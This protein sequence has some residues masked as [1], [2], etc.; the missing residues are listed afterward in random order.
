MMNKLKGHWEGLMN[1]AP[2]NLSTNKDCF[3]ELL[4]LA[5]RPKSRFDIKGDEKIFV[6]RAQSDNIATALAILIILVIPALLFYE[7]YG[8]PMYWLCEIATLAAILLFLRCFPSANDIEVNTLEQT[9]VIRSNSFIGRHII[10]E[11]KIL[12][13]EFQRFSFNR[14]SISGNFL[15]RRSNRVYIHARPKTQMLIDLPN[16]PFYYVN[17][18]VFTDCLTRIIKGSA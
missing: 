13:T 2:Q 9:V 16:G 6:I 8:N 12:F 18:K 1:Y 5:T 10:P 14:S 17:H 3:E 15:V 4:K 7:D 11:R